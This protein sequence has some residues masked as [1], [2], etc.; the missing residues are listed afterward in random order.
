M[1]MPDYGLVNRRSLPPIQKISPQYK[2]RNAKNTEI[3]ACDNIALVLYV[4]TILLFIM[5]QATR[6]AHVCCWSSGSLEKCLLS[7][8]S[9]DA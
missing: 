9:V 3:A 1:K 5:M 6:K 8:T 7:R 4:L 2:T